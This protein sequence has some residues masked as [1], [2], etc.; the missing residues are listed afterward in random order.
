[1]WQR[2]F[3]RVIVE[4]DDKVLFPGKKWK[5]FVEIFEPIMAFLAQHGFRRRVDEFALQKKT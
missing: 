3:K 4:R 2:P 1:M 5:H